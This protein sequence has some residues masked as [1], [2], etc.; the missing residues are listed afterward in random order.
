MTPG[1]QLVGWLK[2]GLFVLF[3]VLKVESVTM[4]GNLFASC[5]LEVAVEGASGVVTSV[6]FPWHGQLNLG[7]EKKQYAIRQIPEDLSYKRGPLMPSAI[8]N[9]FRFLGLFDL[10][11]K[12]TKD[13]GGLEGSNFASMRS[14]LAHVTSTP[15]RELVFPGRLIRPATAG[16]IFREHRN[17]GEPIA[18]IMRAVQTKGVLGKRHRKD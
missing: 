13:P 11:L 5:R 17:T 4:R 18:K 16:D 15:E 2:N 1:T 6:P 3:K 7:H 12:D 8:D 10:P 9:I 14:V